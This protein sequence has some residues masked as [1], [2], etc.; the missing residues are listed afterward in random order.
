MLFVL[1]RVQ[2][3]K[4]GKYIRYIYGWV[5]TRCNTSLRQG[6]WTGGKIKIKLLWVSCREGPWMRLQPRR[7]PKPMIFTQNHPQTLV[8]PLLSGLVT[9]KLTSWHNAMVSIQLSVS[10]GTKTWKH[11]SLVDKSW[12]IFFFSIHGL[13]FS[14]FVTTLYFQSKVFVMIYNEFSFKNWLEKQQTCP[15]YSEQCLINCKKNITQPNID[16]T[17]QRKRIKLR[18]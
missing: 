4:K 16:D 12:C 2:E 1:S 17:G 3:I 13:F 11:K 15:K 10:G 14:H 6:H 18:A 5:A 7:T 8:T 9:S